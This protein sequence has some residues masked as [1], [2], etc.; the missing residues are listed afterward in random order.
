MKP[1]APLAHRLGAAA[2]EL[3]PTRIQRALQRLSPP[4]PRRRR[5]MPYPRMHSLGFSPYAAGGVDRINRDWMP[6][7]MSSS[8]ELR[9]SLVLARNRGRD[10]RINNAYAQSFLRLGRVNIV[11]PYGFT[12]RPQILGADGKPDR[13]FNRALARRHQRWASG[14]VTLDRS[15]SLARSLALAWDTA[16]TEGE[17]FVRMIIDAPNPDGLALQHIDADLIDVQFNRAPAYGQN[18]IRMGVELDAFGAPV[19]YWVNNPS[20]EYGWPV[21]ERYFVPAYDP[22]TGRGEMLHLFW[23]DRVNQVRGIS[24]FHAATEMLH[25]IGGLV[26]AEIYSSRV[27]AGPLGFIQ[28]NEHSDEPEDLEDEADDTQGAAAPDGEP[29]PARALVTNPQD[30]AVGESAFY[31]LH[32]GETVQQWSSDHPN[33]ALPEVLKGMLEGAISGIGGLYFEVAGNYEAVNFTSSRAGQLSQREVWRMHQETI[34]EQLALPIYRTW[35][36]V[37]LLRGSLVIAGRRL[38]RLAQPYSDVDIRGR[39]WEHIQPLEDRQGD[40]LGVSGGL[41]SRRRVLADENEDFFEIVDELSEENEYADGKGVDITPPGTLGNQVTESIAANR[42]KAA[43]E[44]TRPGTK[45]NGNGANGSKPSQSLP[46]VSNHAPPV[47][48]SRF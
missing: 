33:T 19:G 22:F 17:A 3:M 44:E 4:P 30:I 21:G 46:S 40:L 10:L 27:S 24:R 38:G 11:G 25:Q 18:E 14:R 47:G 16:F 36:R 45:K 35:L 1:R 32:R 42:A 29:G 39:G 13:L 5:L 37:G 23:P 26:E 31:R 8:A 41:T 12:Y 7:T 6:G 43:Q 48:A 15:L 34:I 20:S 2:F 28:P 9:E